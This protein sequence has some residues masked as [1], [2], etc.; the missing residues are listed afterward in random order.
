[1]LFFRQRHE[2]LNAGNRQQ[3][4]RGVLR[5]FAGPSPF[6]VAGAQVIRNDRPIA[7]PAEMPDS[8]PVNN[9]R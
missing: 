8:H 5:S 3:S 2:L 6:L 7:L 9:D 1:M 4:R